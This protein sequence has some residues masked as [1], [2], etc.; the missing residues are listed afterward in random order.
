M[1]IQTDA[2]IVGAGPVGLFQVFELG[3]LGLKAELIDSLPQVG[4]QCAELYPE[5]PIYDIPAWPV[6]GAQELVDKL[7]EQ[8]EPFHAGIHLG[9]RVEKFERRDDGRFTVVT[10]AG[11]EFDAGAVIIAAG[12]GAFQPRK[13]K[14]KGT[15]ELDAG[16]IHYRVTERE[17]FRGKRLLI[18]GGGDS[19]LDWTMD[20]AEIAESVELI[21]RRNEYRGA[22]ASAEKVRALAAE[23]KVRERQGIITRAE[24]TDDGGIRFDM[25][26][27][28]RN[29]FSVDGDEVLVFW[30]L[31]PD[32]GPI[33]EWGLDLEKKQIPVDT[34][35]FQTS[36]EGVF[37]IGDVNTYPGKK[38]FIL[39]GF[40]EAA[41]A[42]FGVQKYVYPEQRQFVQYTTTSPIM[43]KRLGVADD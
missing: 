1:S 3:L 24:S 27:L 25:M 33:A 36:V 39:S 15:D 43:H 42:A 11:T 34:E 8:I 9:Q 10:S 19:A 21:H 22:A 2:V 31:A 7:I 28:E 23:G 14:A 38:K 32:L 13:L 16:R 26:D 29:K 18:L 30:G 5:K 41:L 4:G 20:L 12:L 40:H 37:A 35:K 17:R 6:I